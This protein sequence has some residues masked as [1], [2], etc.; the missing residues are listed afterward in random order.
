MRYRPRLANGKLVSLPWPIAM[1]RVLNPTVWPLEDTASRWD[2]FVERALLVFSFLTFLQH[3][4][5]DLNYLLDNLNDM[6]IM[7]TGMP[8]YL[9]LVEIQIRGFQLARH[10]A[11]FKRVLQKFYAEIYVPQ[12]TESN[13]YARI[14]R[15]MLGTRINSIMYIMALLNFFLVPI[16]NIIYHRR[17]MLYKQ[18]YPFDN[19]QL[20]FYIPLIGTNIFVGIIITT[21]LFG[22]LNVLGEILMHMNAR[23]G[24]LGEHLRMTAK[25]LLAANT[26][27]KGRIARQYRQALVQILRRNV[28]LNNF[29]AQVEAQFSFRIFILFAFSAALLCALS[30]KSYTNPSANFTYIVWF[31][32]K[33]LELLAFG[34]LGSILYKT[35]DELGLMYYTSGWEQIVYHSS[36]VRENVLLM[37]MLT[38][39]IEINSQ[40]FFLTGLKYFRV[41]LV[42]VVKIIQG[43]FSYFTFLVSL[44]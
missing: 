14:Q 33:F 30:F 29:G 25:H 10:K 36:N 18:L 24:Q 3:H 35:T 43:A 41:T 19:T 23:Y 38:L 5:V 27:D 39:A 31:V 11:A 8:T 22:E 15:Q 17:E 13:T 34:M 37:K 16:Q 4:A 7:L 12:A 21:M 28:E 42:A 44:R 9:I 32:A 1:Y 20:R 6:D 26:V 40:P 2:I